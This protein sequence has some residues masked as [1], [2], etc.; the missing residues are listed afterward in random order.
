M[1]GQ[2][3]GRRLLLRAGTVRQTEWVDPSGPSWI[4]IRPHNPPKTPKYSPTR[5]P[6][7]VPKRTLGLAHTTL[8]RF[9][10]ACGPQGRRLGAAKGGAIGGQVWPV[11]PAGGLLGGAPRPSA[12]R[13]GPLEGGPS[14]QP[15]PAGPTG[16]GPLERAPQGCAPRGTGRLRAPPRGRVRD[17]VLEGPIPGVR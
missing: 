9:S 14:P 15:S 5:A 2:W 3:M 10:C 4:Q 1:G 6:A 7:R 8:K 12:P 17:T 16:P 13:E 11:T